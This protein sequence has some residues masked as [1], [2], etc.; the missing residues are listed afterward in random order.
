M[1]GA[2]VVGLGIALCVLGACRRERERP[3]EDAKLGRR[4]SALVL[5]EGDVAIVNADSSVEMAVIGQNIVVRLSDKTM[6]HIR[7]ETDTS[8]VRD[9]GFAGS[10]ERLVKSTVQSALSQQVRYPLAEVTGARY[11]DG[12]IKLDVNGGQPRLF[13]STKIGG[14]RLMET[15]RREDAERFVAAVNARRQAR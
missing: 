5:G 10:I 15:F 2:L 14:K 8:A 4:D 12:E 11:E 13:T 9:S 6:A 3:P 7:R 1:R